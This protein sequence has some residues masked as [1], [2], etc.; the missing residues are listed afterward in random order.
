MSKLLNGVVILEGITHIEDL[1]TDKFIDTVEK[2]KD[3]IVTEKMDGANLWFGV[4]EK[5][6]YTSREGKNKNQP[7]FYSVEDYP[8][9]ANYNGF[10]A[11][12]L[13]FESVKDIIEDVLSVGDSVETEI[14]F[15]KQPNTVT[16]GA[17]GM[18]YI[19][20][21]R[22]I[23][24]NDD[25]VAKLTKRLDDRVVEV[26]SIIVSSDDGDTLKKDEEE[27]A[28]KFTDVK[29]IDSSKI[30]SN[31][32]LN[33]LSDMKAFLKKKNEK[34]PM[35]NGE[36]ASVKL[37]SISKD[38]RDA[39]KSEREAVLATLM[40]DY[41]LP[42]KEILLNKYVR[43]VKPRLQSSELD[44][45]EDIGMEGVVLRDK[46]SDDQVKLV[47]KD[48]FTAI[49]KFNNQVRSSVSGLVRTD[50]Q[51]APIELRG[52][53]FGQAKIRIAQ[54]LGLKELAVSS[55]SKKT[56]A[57]FKKESFESTAEALA[58]S[59]NI[60]SL[61]SIKIKISAILENSLEDIDDILV[62]F[63]NDA[64]SY[65]LKLK[66]G[67]EIGISPEV[68][69]RNLTAFAETKRDIH[70][71]NKAVKNASS[72]SELIIAL[73]GR[74]IK[75]L[76]DGNSMKE[77]FNLIKAVNEDAP[78]GTPDGTPTATVS[79]AIQPFVKPLFSKN[80]SKRKRKFVAKNRF[81]RPTNES[82]LQILEFEISNQNATDVD[83]KAAAQS[84]VDFK[85]LR[86][87]INM[88]DTLTDQDVNR[89]LDKAHEINDEVDTV[90]F[91]ME[92]DD[93]SVVKVYVN[94]T[95]ADEFEESLSKLL[96]EYDDVEEAINVLAQTFDIVD[97]EWPNQAPGEPSTSTDTPKSDADETDINT[98]TNPDVNPV[99][100]IS[101]S[102]EEPQSSADQNLN[103][104]EP[105]DS[106]MSIDATFFDDGD[107]SPDTNDEEEKKAGSGTD[108]VEDDMTSNDNDIV[109]GEEAIS[110]EE[111]GEDNAP[112][113]ND[114]EESSEDDEEDTES[115]DDKSDDEEE[116]D[117][118]D[119]VKKKKSTE[120]KTEESMSVGQQLKQKLLTEKKSSKKDE[121][122]EDEKLDVTGAIPAQ[123]EKLLDSFPTRGGKAMVVLLYALGA[124]ID[125][126]SLKK[127]ELRKT[128][129]SAAER[130]VKDSQFRVWVKRL[131]EVLL[132]ESATTEAAL[133]DELGNVLQRI[134][135][136]IMQA[137]GLPTAVEKM[138]RAT[139]RKSV[140]VKATLAMGNPKIRQY[141]KIV[142]EMLGID[143]AT[144]EIKTVNEAKNANGEQEFATFAG[145]K[146][147]VKAKYANVWYDGEGKDD[148]ANAFIGAKPFAK[149]KTV[150]VGY[151]DGETGTIYKDEDVKR[152]SIS[153]DVPA[154]DQSADQTGNEFVDEV[155]KLAA[156]VGIPADVINYRRKQTEMSVRKQRMTIKNSAQILRNIKKLNQILD[157]S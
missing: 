95:Q 24:V 134:I 49:N 42:I 26:E 66:T 10:R 13:A 19:V 104:T 115:T 136:E 145:W 14:L 157:A 135:Y 153:E 155:L 38:E 53:A 68:M 55:T 122:K 154:A 9:V 107:A 130:Y 5:G 73:Y 142:A 127:A 50:D 75:S 123:V 99:I 70:E 131:T 71:I 16:Y 52:G 143:G 121:K 58:S 91:G 93:G 7:R 152:H 45:S 92:L 146:R 1:S 94:A 85:N 101:G 105:S 89:Y 119:N 133:E 21:L 148:T 112:T 44:S 18:N 23:S 140:K 69:K 84:D 139:L 3:K 118:P 36:V 12:H 149:G 88:S 64:S 35:T 40:N 4:D 15:G 97:V 76:F 17:S 2:L 108:S 41:K 57:K 74:T 8:I 109:G 141:L 86:N 103:S 31:D 22:G 28:W 114:D 60:A 98:D 102:E 77:S 27:V 39:M 54:L 144:G 124:P 25:K 46:D 116:E 6:L 61:E 129:D 65:K 120:T 56:L 67:K 90:T 113:P 80:V 96:G 111:D 151:W 37:G 156:A 79:S 51:D 78:D 72:P 87:T 83:D 117:S 132:K 32:A 110:D 81:A 137:I 33:L 126:L 106:D 43:S 128:V 47:D 63:K 20:I 150:E 100:D 11:A 59:V 48:V 30:I 34:F 125:A 82:L 147:A 138:A 29:P 62:K